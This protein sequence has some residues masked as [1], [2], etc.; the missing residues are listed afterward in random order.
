[1]GKNYRFKLWLQLGN[2][3]MK[4][5]TMLVCNKH[6]TKT[7]HGTWRVEFRDAK[8]NANRK[9]ILNS[10]MIRL[11]FIGGG[12]FVLR[13]V[14]SVHGIFRILEYLTGIF[15]SCTFVVGSIYKDCCNVYIKLLEIISKRQLGVLQIV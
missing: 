3:I 15:N 13:L 1:M 7:I 4:F 9:R 8:K 14:L 10:N 6:N 5:K 2:I 12:D 11:V